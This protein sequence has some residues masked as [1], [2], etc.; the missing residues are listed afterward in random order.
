GVGIS[1]VILVAGIGLA[2]AAIAWAPER[3]FAELVM[4]ASALVFGAIF[5]LATHLPFLSK[6][7]KRLGKY[8][9]VYSSLN[10]LLA[11]HVRTILDMEGIEAFIYN[12]HSVHLAPFDPKGARVMVPKTKVASAESIL[13]DFGLI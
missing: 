1:L 4:V 7:P 5:A 3:L 2:A 13:R 9:E 12:K 10:P 11:E 8:Q 6:K